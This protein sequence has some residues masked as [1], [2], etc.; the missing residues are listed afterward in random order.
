MSDNTITVN[1]EFIKLARSMLTA[2]KEALKS[3]HSQKAQREAE[4][5]TQLFETKLASIEKEVARA[6]QFSEPA[7]F[8]ERLL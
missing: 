4:R 5:L 6:H 7:T 2:Q 8:P 1:A 3:R